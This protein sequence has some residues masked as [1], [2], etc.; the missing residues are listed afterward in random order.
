MSDI[1]STVCHLEIKQKSKKVFFEISHGDETK[2]MIEGAVIRKGLET[3]I[4]IGK[5]G[6]NISMTKDE[7]L[8]F[9]AC[10]DNF[11]E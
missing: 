7:Y 3:H 8:S 11:L 2:N 9:V 6:N 1:N 10:A 5:D 4:C